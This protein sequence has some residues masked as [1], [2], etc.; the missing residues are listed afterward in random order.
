MGVLL[1]CPHLAAQV[2]A[3]DKSCQVSHIRKRGSFCESCTDR[4]GCLQEAAAG[5]LFASWMLAEPET[6]QT[7]TGA[8][9]R[10]K[11]GQTAS[12]EA[13][14]VSKAFLFSVPPPIVG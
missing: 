14:E 12:W 6:P 9:A 11:C 2:K 1:F 4:L 3:E 5:T 8:P 7:P 13:A 10:D